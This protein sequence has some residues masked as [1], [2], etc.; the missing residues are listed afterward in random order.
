MPS[1]FSTRRTVAF[2]VGTVLMILGGLVFASVFV[3]GALDR[4]PFVDFDGKS[5][6]SMLRGII[7]MGLVIVGGFVRMLGARGVAGSGLV[8]DPEQARQDLKPHSR[9]VGGVVKDVLEGADIQLG[10]KAQRVVMVKCRACGRLNEEDS[11]FCQECAQ[12]L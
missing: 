1:P 6:S 5:R 11:K 3:T 8:L 12:A 10:A 4:D 2:Y 9:M 7:G